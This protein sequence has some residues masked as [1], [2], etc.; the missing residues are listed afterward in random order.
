MSL[1]MQES[2]T[3]ESV[4]IM[5]YNCSKRMILMIQNMRDK[6][7]IYRTIADKMGYSPHT[8]ARYHRLYEKFGIEVFADDK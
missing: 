7:Y 3:S 4:N 8:I 2:E 5:V 1:Y 6:G